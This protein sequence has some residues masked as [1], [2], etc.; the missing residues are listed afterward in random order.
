MLLRRHLSA[1]FLIKA[2]ILGLNIIGKKII[3]LSTC[4]KRKKFGTGRY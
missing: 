4:E 3:L 2:V 1:T